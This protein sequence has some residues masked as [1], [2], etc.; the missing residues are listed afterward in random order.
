MPASL[1]ADATHFRHALELVA[2]AASLLMGTVPEW[3][4]LLLL[5]LLVCLSIR[6]PSRPG[7]ESRQTSWQRTVPFVAGAIVAAGQLAIF[8]GMVVR[9]PPVYDQADHRLWYYPLPFQ[10]LLVALLALLLGRLSMGA[11]RVRPAIVN[12]LLAAIVV[13]NVVQWDIHWRRQRGSPWFG[14]VERES[15]ALQ[16][17]LHDGR[18]YTF[19]PGYLRFYRYCLTLSPASAK[20]AQLAKDE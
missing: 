17:A 11:T 9:H 12:V 16:L 14:T 3:L 13:S 19:H 5:A 1:L 4:A 15:R 2:Q 6:Q 20:R 18:P 7:V 8:A 10:A